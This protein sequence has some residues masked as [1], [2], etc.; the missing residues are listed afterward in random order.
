MGQCR[1]DTAASRSA[2]SDPFRQIAAQ[3][4]AGQWT[5]LGAEVG[6]GPKQTDEPQQTFDESSRLP[7]GH[8]EQDF[9]G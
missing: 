3:S 8:A 4:P 9:H 1:H 6:H 5:A 7:Q 2:F